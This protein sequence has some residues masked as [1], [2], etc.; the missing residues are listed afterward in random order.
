METGPQVRVSSDGDQTQD[1][2]VQ[3]EGLNKL[4]NTA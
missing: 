2:W 3:G 1:L 4:V